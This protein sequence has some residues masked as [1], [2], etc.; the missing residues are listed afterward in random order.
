MFD[1]DQGLHQRFDGFF[2]DI[3]AFVFG[4]N[5]RVDF[6]GL[7]LVLF[8][9]LAMGIVPEQRDTS[10]G[11]QREALMASDLDQLSRLLCF[12]GKRSLINYEVGFRLRHG[13]S[14]RNLGKCKSRN[15]W[16]LYFP[17]FLIG[18][19]AR[20]SISSL[21]AQAQDARGGGFLRPFVPI[22]KGCNQL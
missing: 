11:G 1:G 7:V 18:K 10:S 6:D 19:L 2:N 22:E 16:L 9:A 14:V 5:E 8:D 21:H 13:L 15:Y 3:V 17:R 4:A 20:P 12:M